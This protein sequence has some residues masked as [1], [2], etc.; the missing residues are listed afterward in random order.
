MCSTAH[1]PQASGPATALLSCLGFQGWGPLHLIVPTRGDPRGLAG[2]LPAAGV[3]EPQTVD[4]ERPAGG[5]LAALLREQRDLEPL[6]PRH[7]PWA[8]EG[9]GIGSR[10]WPAGWGHRYLLVCRRGAGCPL[11]LSAWHR[12]GDTWKRLCEPMAPASFRQ[13]YL[14]TPPAPSRDRRGV[15]ES[16]RR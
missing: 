7:W 11:R 13:R 10:P 4:A 14:G 15:P 3:E 1:P 2:R 16:L 12:Q 5:W 6:D 8:R 9:S